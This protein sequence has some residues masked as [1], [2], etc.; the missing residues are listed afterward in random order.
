MRDVS[1]AGRLVTTT[2]AIAR[3]LFLYASQ[4][5]DAG[6]TDVVDFPVLVDGATTN[7][8]LLIGRNL[9]LAAV[10]IPRTES[11]ALAGEDSALFELQRRGDDLRARGRDVPG[12][13]LTQSP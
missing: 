7:C 3:Q 8:T 2:N 1:A 12:S 13:P 10:T 11:G 5:A 6:L 4:L 9:P